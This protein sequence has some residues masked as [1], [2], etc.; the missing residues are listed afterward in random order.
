M[1]YK[2]VVEQGVGA[3][4]DRTDNQGRYDAVLRAQTIYLYNMFPCSDLV[5]INWVCQN[6]AETF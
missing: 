3:A 5:T 4:A 1:K 6:S 2:A